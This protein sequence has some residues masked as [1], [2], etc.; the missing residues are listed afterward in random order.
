V[1]AIKLVVL[2]LRLP[3]IDQT[4]SG[5]SDTVARM[6]RRF[7]VFD[8]VVS[9]LL[10]TAVVGA[11][12]A[13]AESPTSAAKQILDSPATGRYVGSDAAGPVTFKISAAKHAAAHRRKVFVVSHFRF[14]NACAPGGTLV[15]G[16]IR[17]NHQ[18]RFD[19][20]AAGIT[21]VGSVNSEF[22]GNFFGNANPVTVRGKVRVRLADCDSGKLSFS[23]N[24]A[25]STGP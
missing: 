8:A 1:I 18:N 16:K 13:V 9:A 17:I 14:A 2:E 4:A 23:A 3:E 5:L 15:P 12:S 6:V 19:F 11:G 24:L 20:N 10:A 21:V 22:P 7:A 25:P